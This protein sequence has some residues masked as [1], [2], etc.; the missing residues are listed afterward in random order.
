ME[1]TVIVFFLYFA[2]V[3]FLFP[4]KNGFAESS[5]EM[6]PKGKESL[7]VGNLYSVIHYEEAVEM[8]RVAPT[9]TQVLP[10]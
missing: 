9:K 7:D 4:T 8:N 1:G 5:G 10:R 3:F 2:F 6:A